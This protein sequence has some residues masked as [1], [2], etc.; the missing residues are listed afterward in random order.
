M[1][2]PVRDRRRRVARGVA[3]AKRAG[4]ALLLG[5]IVFVVAGL[6]GTF[7]GTVAVG[8]AICLIAGAIL[9]APAIVLGYAVNAAERDDRQ[10]GL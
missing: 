1:T 7:S 3:M 4:Y 2:D 10:R 8:A 6:V 9:L 5:S